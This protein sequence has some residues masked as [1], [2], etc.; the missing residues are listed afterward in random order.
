MQ[1]AKRKLKRK[2]KGNFKRKEEKIRKSKK[3]TIAMLFQVI[4]T[5]LL[6]ARVSQ[7]IANV[8]LGGCHGILAGG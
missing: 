4:A 2:F 3:A 7:A 5:V 6:V 1:T 8:L